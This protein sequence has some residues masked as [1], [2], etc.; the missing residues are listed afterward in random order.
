MRAKKSQARRAASGL[1]PSSVTIRMYNVGFGDCF[2]LTF[3]YPKEKR[4]ML[5]DFGTTSAP[6][7]QPKDYMKR[8]AADIKAQCGS[9]LHIVVATHRHRDHISGFATD[10]E[11]T[12]AIIAGLKPDYVIQPW[13]EDPNAKPDALT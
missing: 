9:K 13:T 5:V 3:H 12:G 4:H 11:G 10:G 6:A 7:G 1:A 2:L 8:I